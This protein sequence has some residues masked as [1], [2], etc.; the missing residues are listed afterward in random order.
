VGASE[1]AIFAVLLSCSEAC[2]NAVRHPV[3][4]SRAAFEVEADANCEEISVI[5]RDF[6]RWRAAKADG[7]PGGMGLMLMRSLM[8]EV[9][10]QRSTSG[11]LVRMRR[12]LAV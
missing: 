4:S 9:R 5:V 10:L 3:Q 8:D 12:R 1:H 11:T 2:G 7:D 6:G